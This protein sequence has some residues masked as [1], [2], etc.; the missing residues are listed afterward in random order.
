MSAGLMMAGLRRPLFA[1]GDKEKAN[2]KSSTQ[3]HLAESHSHQAVR[4]ALL[5]RQRP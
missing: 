3:L 1:G 5:V 2:K 4:S